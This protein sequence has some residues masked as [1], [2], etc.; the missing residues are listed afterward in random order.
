MPTPP[1]SPDDLELPPYV[2][3]HSAESVKVIYAD[4][5]LLLIRKPD[6]L[7]SVPGRHPLNHDCMITRLQERYPD[8]LVVHRLDLDTSGIMIVARGKPSQAALSRL[9]QERSVDKQ[10]RAWV[11]GDVADDEGKIDLPIARDWENR[12]LQKICAETG[13]KS[14]TYFKVL[15]RENGNSYLELQPATGRTHQLRIHCREMGHPIL[16]C[17]MYAPP[18]ILGSAPRLMLHASRIAFPHPVTGR[19]LVG[20]CP[21]P[22]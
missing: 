8:A 12:P 22:F 11:A 5:S 17:D 19:K 13:K 10:Y 3:P 16:G 21:A 15:K 9:F 6:L 1:D 20:H 14:L 7:L 18:A 2:V 4:E